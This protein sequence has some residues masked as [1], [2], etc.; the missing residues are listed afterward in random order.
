[1]PTALVTGANRGIGYAIADGL[2]AAGTTVWAACRRAPDAEDAA[3]RLGRGARAIALDLADRNSIAAL[4]DAHGD[5]F[6]V[7]V[8]NAGVLRRRSLLEHPEDYFEAMQVMVDA[9]FLL[10]R[11]LIPAM[12]ERGRGRIVNVSSG[13]GAF[14]EGLEGPGAYGIAKAALNALTVRL[15][16]ETPDSIKVNALCPGWVRTR[17]GGEEATRSPEEGAETA[18]WLAMLDDDGPSGGFFRDRRP[19]DW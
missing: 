4:A 11:A 19:I 14:A 1:M 13:G 7:L 15:D 9:P 8:N 3:E 12:N 18:I 10:S 16:A 6:D 17:M 5:R 2:L